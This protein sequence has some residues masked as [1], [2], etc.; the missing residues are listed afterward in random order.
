VNFRGARL[1]F[2][3]FRGANL[4]PLVMRDGRRL[5]T[6]FDGAALLGAAFD[7]GT[8]IR[9]TVVQPETVAV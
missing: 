7:E 6:D 5:E 2:A 3:D 1:G 8:P 4:R 9:K